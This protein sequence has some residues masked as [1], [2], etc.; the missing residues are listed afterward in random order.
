MSGRYYAAWVFSV[1]AS[2][3]HTGVV[4]EIVFK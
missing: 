3:D 4:A 1:A 2:S